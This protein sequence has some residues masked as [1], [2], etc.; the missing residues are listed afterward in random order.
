MKIKAKIREQKVKLKGLFFTIG[1]IISFLALGCA[2]TG[3]V[4]QSS[5]SK[6]APVLT[7]IDVQDYA[8]TITAGKPFTYAIYRAGDPYKMVVDI[9][10]MSIGAFNTRII[11]DKAGITEVLPS[12]VT[13]PAFMAR[14]E[15]L[16]QTPSLA[17]TEF[18]NTS[19]VVRV[20]KEDAPKYVQEE[21]KE[22]LETK[23][24]DEDLAKAEDPP[25]IAQ[26][27]QHNQST[28][29]ATAATAKATEINEI[30]L[31]KSS[32]SIR[33]T[34]KGNGAM[35]PSV[36]P[37]ENRIVM[38]IPDVVMNTSI[39]ASVI[40]PLKGI[41]SA[42]Y[43]DKVRLV[44]DLKKPAEFDV[45]A[46]GSS[47][48]M[49]L[50]KSGK[51]P[52][53]AEAAQKRSQKSED[54][55]AAAETKS[56]DK[57]E[58]TDI[59][60]S[61]SEGR[62]TGKKISLDFQ[63]TDI[64]PIFRL[65]AD[66]SGYNIIV[67]PEV[68]GKL[69]MKLINVPWDQALDLMLKTTTPPLGKA[70]EGNIIRIAPHSV[71]TQESEETAKASEAA[72]KAEHLDTRI[73]PISYAKVLDVEKSIKDSKMLSPRG[74]ISYDERT[75]SLVINDV[76]SVFPRI[77]GL[78]ANLDKPTPQVMIEARI[79]EVNTSDV[80]DLGIQWG[81]NYR[82][83]NNLFNF[84]G[85]RGLNTG[86]TTGGKYLVDFP[87][88]ASPGSGTGFNFGILNAAKTMGLDL[89]ISALQSIGKGKIVSNPRIMTVDNGKAFISQGDSIPIRK[90]TPEG[91]ISTEFKDFALSLTVSPHITPD[92]SV[93]MGIEARKEEPDWTRVSLEGTPASKKR[94]AN[95]NVI[96]RDG[97]TIV[98]G[99]VFKT[100]KQDTNT[101]VPG[102]MNIP[103]IGWLFKNNKM[104][105]D[106]SEMLIFI[107]PRIVHKPE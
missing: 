35:V 61:I 79:I 64:I 32:G 60:S 47:V 83:P 24:L 54:M 23:E 52:L 57:A 59:I 55:Q 44:F 99:G 70:V 27:A 103:I 48:V 101:G 33:V 30:L 71:F 87:A 6:G 98:I 100:S 40:S 19:L 77:E 106:T 81:F 84:G 13:S 89:Q 72:I 75:T 94:E 49:V 66:I 56:P 25:V 17:E 104:T 85:M 74:N 91:T 82:T 69:T 16:L 42:K 93:S 102:L 58:I 1:I 96:I 95:T 62:Y 46:S 28:Q 76:P 36:F 50:Q 78:L 37:L 107:T 80:K 39:P 8:L 11:S 45:T 73:F 21:T 63:D 92:N 18:R 105:E 26:T 2:T 12:Q 34:I 65:L 97:E 68:K 43:K 31:D 29:P 20:K 15:I 53:E 14:L 9:P 51:E 5:P 88:G 86:A 3:T 7:K 90:L 41:R 4:S 22:A 38:D 10:D 67:S